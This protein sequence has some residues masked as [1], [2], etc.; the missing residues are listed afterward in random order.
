MLGK[1]GITSNEQLSQSDRRCWR[2][3]CEIQLESQTTEN[4][5][6]RGTQIPISGPERPES[7]THRNSAILFPS[8]PRL[9]DYSL[10][11]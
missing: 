11:T 5:G 4:V 10:E 7:L 8:S 3:R 9:H 2:D 6:E 1:V